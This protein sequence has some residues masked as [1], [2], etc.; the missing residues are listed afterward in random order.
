[1]KILPIRALSVKVLNDYIYVLVKESTKIMLQILDKNLK[2]IDKFVSI[3]GNQGFILKIFKDG[4]LISIDN[5]LYLVQDGSAEIVLRSNN[6]NNI[7][8]HAVEAEGKIYVHEYGVSPT[9]IFVSEDLRRWKVVATNLDIDRSDIAYDP[10]RKWLIVTLGDG[11]L[12]RVAVSEN[13]GSSW[14]P[15]YKGPW[16]FFPILVLGDR[17]VFGMDS[18]IARGGIS[19]YNFDDRR[20]SHIFLRWCNS[21]VKLAQMRDL[22]LVDNRFFVAGLGTPQAVVVSRDMRHWYLVYIEGFDDRFNMHMEIGEGEDFV[23]CA[24]G[25]SLVVVGKDELEKMFTVQR[26]VL[27]SYRACIGRLIGLGFILK[28]TLL[29][30]SSKL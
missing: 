30:F 14:K 18:G 11:N 16:Q 27:T 10:Y 13:E 3:D 5:A 29:P 25:K 8:P 28:R 20:W 26:L 1:M 21:D 22:K 17:L 12:V 6:P 9:R 15:L 4:I 24:T 19:V 2:I 23:A 7:F